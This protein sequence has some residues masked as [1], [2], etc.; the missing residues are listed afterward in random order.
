MQFHPIF[1][2]SVITLLAIAMLAWDALKPIRN[3]QRLG[4]ALAGILGI[5]FVA[6]LQWNVSTPVALGSIY[7]VDK[8]GLFFKSLFLLAS[9]GVMLLAAERLRVEHFVIQLLATV[10]MLVVASSTDMVLMFVA[11]ELVTIAFYVLISYGDMRSLEAGAKYL[12]IGAFAGGMLAYGISYVYGATGSTAIAAITQ[13][14]QTQELTFGLL[15][16]LGALTFKLAAFPGQMWAPDV[17]QNAPTPVSAFLAAGSK[18]AG[19]VLFLRV[20]TAAS[21][22]RPDFWRPVIVVCS[23]LTI[24][25][26]NFAALQQKSLKRLLGCSSMAHAGYML[27]GLV[28]SD[29]FAAQSVLF[30]LGQYVFGVLAIFAIAQVLE[31]NYQ[32]DN[33]SRV[34]GLYKAS[35][36]LAGSLA[37]TLMSLAGIPPLS[38]F[39]AKY[40]V[41]AALLRTGM[42]TLS[43]VLLTAAIIGILIGF[44]YYLTA[45]RKAFAGETPLPKL[46]IPFALRCLIAVCVFMIIVLGVW[47]E[48]LAIAAQEAAAS[49]MN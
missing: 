17:Y 5:L 15:F 36:F 22:T 28:N 9:A 44:V 19:L 10:G 16:V 23:I 1:F 20:L 3:T 25:Y 14:A 30:Y 45:L 46:V 49:L 29:A 34:A 11:L 48:P 12:I 33:I 18:A 31:K 7:Q 42:T 43:A 8:L 27:L 40:F 4:Q 39:I 13:T 24:L 21:L 32:S 38:G 2:E 35:P 6:S 26:G 37:L 47:Q 41:I